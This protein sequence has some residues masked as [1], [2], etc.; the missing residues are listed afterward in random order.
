ML[1]YAEGKSVLN[2]DSGKVE[3]SS[4]MLISDPQIQERRHRRYVL[5][6][7]HTSLPMSKSMFSHLRG[8]EKAMRS[9]LNPRR[10]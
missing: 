1:P 2:Y 10:P 6:F 3:T 8:G 9:F 5:Y 4:S 7:S